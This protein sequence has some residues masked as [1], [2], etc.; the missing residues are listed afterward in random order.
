VSAAPLKVVGM[1]G[2]SSDKSTAD[3]YRLLN[4]GVQKRLGG[5]NTAEV[6]IH[7]M[8]F[9]LSERWVRTTALHADAVVRMALGE[10]S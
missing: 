4:E 5:W 1:L 6:L 2:G 7:S 10:A 3:Y 9:A 8:N